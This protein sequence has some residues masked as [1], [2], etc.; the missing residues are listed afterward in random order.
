MMKK[1]LLYGFVLMVCMVA[2]C[3]KDNPNNKTYLVKQ[4]IT[5]ASAEGVPL[6]TANYTYDDKNRITKITDGTHPNM[7]TFTMVY[8]SQNRV[9]TASKYADNGNLIIEFDFFYNTGSSGYIFHGS[10][11]ADTAY[12]TFNSKNQVTLINTKHSGSQ[13]FTYDSKGNVATTTAVNADGSIDLGDETSFAY[14]NEKNPFSD[15]PANNYFFM[16]IVKIGNPSTLINNVVVRDADTYTY[17]YNSAGFP[18]SAS[19]ATLTATSAVTLYI[20]YNY[21]VK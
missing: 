16:Y 18:T 9:T 13:Q 20:Y 8:D 17:N 6:D 2:G 3:K 1:S 12:F 10:S 4:Q 7:V 11:L 15:I 14:D 5:D 19:I 21:I